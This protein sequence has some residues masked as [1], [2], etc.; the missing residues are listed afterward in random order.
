MS[1]TSGWLT[2]SAWLVG[3]ELAAAAAE[4]YL[5]LTG[6]AFLIMLLFVGYKL[7]KT[8]MFTIWLEGELKQSRIHT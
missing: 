7:I 3:V 5:G 1:L 4:R 6:F 8:S 2:T